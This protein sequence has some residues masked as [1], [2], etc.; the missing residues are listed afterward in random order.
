M[1]N[2]PEFEV[3]ARLLDSERATLTIFLPIYDR[4]G[5]PLNKQVAMPFKKYLAFR[6]RVMQQLNLTENEVDAMK[7]VLPRDEPI[8]P[9]PQPTGE[10]DA[11]DPPVPA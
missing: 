6:A 5:Q 4:H 2:Q 9:E 8:Q 10:P 11:P 3:A 1:S 7:W